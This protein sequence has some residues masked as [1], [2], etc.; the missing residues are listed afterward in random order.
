MSDY[1]WLL[2]TNII[3]NIVRFPQGQ[4]AQQLELIDNDA[5][6]TSIIVAAELRYG[7]AKLGSTRFAERLESVLELLPILALEP[8]ADREYG[9]IRAYLE[10]K[11]MLIGPNDMLI[12]AQARAGDMAVVTDNVGEFGRVP[13][14]RVINWLRG[15]AAVAHEP[16]PRHHSAPR[17]TTRPRKKK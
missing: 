6:C 3:S 8:P 12:A 9:D 13:R 10:R 14:L 1:A 5:V 2:D 11:G 15:G 4:A 17:K 16:P 7:A